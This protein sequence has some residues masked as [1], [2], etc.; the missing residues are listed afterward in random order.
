M[1]ILFLTN[2]YP[3][4]NAPYGGVGIFIQTTARWLVEMG[5]QVTVLGINNSN[6]SEDIWDQGVRIYRVPN[7]RVRG[8]IW[9]FNCVKINRKIREI[10]IQKGIDVIEGAELSFAFINKIISIKYVIRLHG[11]HHFFAESENRRIFWWK[12]Y[13]ERRS[14]KKADFI[15]GVSKYVM[16]H[17]SKYLDYDSKKQGIIFNPANL[18]KFYEADYSKIIRGRIFFAGTICEKKGI[19]QLIQAMPLI[20]KEIPYASLVIAGRDWKFPDSGNSFTDFLKQNIDENL[21]SSITFLG[22]IANDE[23]PKYIEESEVCCY[24]SHMEAMPLAWI[25]AMSMGKSIVGSL[26]GPGPEIILNGFNGLLCDPLNPDDIAEKII[27]MLRNEELAKSMGFNA[28]NFAL[29]NFSIEK[30]GRNNLEFYKSI[31]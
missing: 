19:R 17:T 2:E 24:P 31:L 28:R 8:L 21:K 26:T 4:L 16:D 9:Y 12:G 14:F 18:I 15:I 5:I 7:S 23:I 13:Q 29:E 20:I 1:H 6:V 11:G 10:H 3:K 25:E 27:F 22:S 30:I